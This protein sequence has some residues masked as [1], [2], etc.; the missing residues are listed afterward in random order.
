MN[1]DLERYLQPD[2][3]YRF[4]QGPDMVR[5]LDDA[6]HNGL[7]CIALAHLVLKDLFDYEL[8]PEFR[9]VELYTD[10]EH[11]EPIE[12][13]DDAQT[14]DLVWFGVEEPAITV[15]AFVPQYAGGE[16]LNWADFPVKHVAICTGETNPDDDYL[17]LHSSREDGV[18]AVW[19]MARFGDYRRYRKLYG[20]SRLK[21]FHRK[22]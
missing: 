2:Y 19:P 21:N 8:P 5:S 16:L 6:R 10:R 11:L 4:T 15:E 13:M 14:G 1:L 3:V 18:N 20:I 7:N 12:S 17:L 9:C 22:A